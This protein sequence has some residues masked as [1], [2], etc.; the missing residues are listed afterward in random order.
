M[1]LKGVPPLINLA[2]LK[3]SFKGSFEFRGSFKGVWDSGSR[4]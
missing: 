2:R 3:G 1:G 4:A